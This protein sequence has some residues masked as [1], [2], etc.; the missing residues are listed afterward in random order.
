M[1]STHP[2]TGLRHLSGN[3]KNNWLEYL[4]ASM[5]NRFEC[6]FRIM[7]K[8]KELIIS[9]CLYPRALKFTTGTLHAVLKEL[10][11]F[12]YLIWKGSARNIQKQTQTQR[13][14]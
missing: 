3:S 13:T 4:V 9:R 7:Q 10:S 11:I 1:H 8:E 6:S 14:D 2:A 12:M 5:D